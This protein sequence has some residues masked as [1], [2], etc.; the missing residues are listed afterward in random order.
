MNGISVEDLVENSQKMGITSEQASD[1][2]YKFVS[3][4]RDKD[5]KN[6]LMHMDE[7]AMRIT[8]NNYHLTN[9]ELNLILDYIYDLQLEA[10]KSRN[11]IKKIK[12]YVK[13][14]EWSKDYEKSSCRTHLLHIMDGE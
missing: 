13:S 11:I 9:Y 2:F 14:N 3:K 4:I 12:K 5:T 10:Y 8:M 7:R 1:N 6:L